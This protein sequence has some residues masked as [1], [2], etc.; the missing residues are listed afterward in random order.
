MARSRRGGG[1]ARLLSG[2]F[3]TK[4]RI[5]RWKGLELVRAVESLEGW[6]HLMRG[7]RRGRMIREL[8]SFA[9]VGSLMGGPAFVGPGPEHGEYAC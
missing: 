2:V 7:A 4:T 1:L 6:G 5:Q 8:I 9:V 3:G